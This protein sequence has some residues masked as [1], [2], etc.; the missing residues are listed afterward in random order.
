MSKDNFS[1][2]E[3]AAAV[4]LA[5]IENGLGRQLTDSKEIMH[6]KEAFINNNPVCK[7]ARQGF[8]AAMLEAE[9]K[10]Y[11]EGFIDGEIKALAH[12]LV[13][14]ATGRKHIGLNRTYVVGYLAEKQQERKDSWEAL[15]T[16]VNSKEED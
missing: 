5:G 15:E 9:N 11:K 10:K 14:G 16:L 8:K 1:L 2:D 13:R 12:I 4:Y 7:E 6:R 3:I